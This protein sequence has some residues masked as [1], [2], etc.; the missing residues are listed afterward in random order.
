MVTWVSNIKNELSEELTQTI[1][2]D[3]KDRGPYWTG[4]FEEGW[5]VFKGSVNVPATQEPIL[6][7]SERMAYGPADYPGP[8][9]V[10]GGIPEAKGRAT[11]TYTIAN[12]TTYRDIAMD[13]DPERVRIGDGN[14]NNTADPDWYLNYMQN[15]IYGVFEEVTDRVAQQTDIKNYKGK[16]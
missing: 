11:Q 2:N 14:R 3:L 7:F 8:S 6:S 13:L 12:I 9:E 1:V 4:Q 15:S 5:R 16:L 10:P